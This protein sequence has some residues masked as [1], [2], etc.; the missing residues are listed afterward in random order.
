M[1]IVACMASE[2][3]SAL[4]RKWLRV[5]ILNLMQANINGNPGH[6]DGG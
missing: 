2:T 3:R 4:V 5:Q 6:S 1:R